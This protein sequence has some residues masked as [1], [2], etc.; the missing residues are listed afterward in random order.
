MLF[1][2]V[3]VVV[4]VVFIIFEQVLVSRAGDRHR[5]WAGRGGANRGPSCKSSRS[6]RLGPFRPP[7]R[8]RWPAGQL[9]NSW[10]VRRQ[11]GRGQL[12]ASIGRPLGALG[13]SLRPPP[14][15]RH[16]HR[17]A[18]RARTRA[19]ISGSQ[20]EAV[21]GARARAE[22]EAE[23]ETEIGAGTQTKTRIRRHRWVRPI[24]APLGPLRNS[25]ASRLVRAS[26]M[27]ANYSLGR[28][29]CRCG[30]W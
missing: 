13:G 12:A 1:A 18:D 25:A 4:V 23:T 6:A 7:V 28:S 3:V 17:R 14:P 30:P 2:R 22:A 5:L 21:A 10:P 20:T 29:G 26:T 27:A 19:L 24:G 16:V 9:N 11:I 8:R 15:P